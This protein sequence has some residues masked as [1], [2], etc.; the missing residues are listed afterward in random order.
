MTSLVLEFGQPA[1]KWELTLMSAQERFSTLSTEPVVVGVRA[2]QSG[3]LLNPTAGVATMA[4]K[5]GALAE[6]VTGDWQASTWD[7]DLIGR[8]VAQC[9][10]GPNGVPLAA[11]VWFVWLQVALTPVTVVKQVGSIVVQ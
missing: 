5:S 8:F 4:F 11:G 7:T 1:A 10:I 9:D 2:F 3:Q 6:P